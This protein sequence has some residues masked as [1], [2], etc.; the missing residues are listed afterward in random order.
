M[1][2]LG[3][4]VWRYVEWFYYVLIA[5]YTD[6][7]FNYSRVLSVIV[8]IFIANFSCCHLALLTTSLEV[9]KSEVMELHKPVGKQ[10]VFS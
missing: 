3:A 6:S 10:L 7:L 5:Y 4:E 9:W 2:A 1:P 8:A